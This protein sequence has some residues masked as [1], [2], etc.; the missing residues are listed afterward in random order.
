MKLLTAEKAI[1]QLQNQAEKIK[2]DEMQRFPAAASFG[3]TWRQ[4]DLYITLIEKVPETAQKAQVRLQLADGN[5]Q[6]SRHCLDSKVGVKMFT[7]ANPEMLDG[8]ILKT[9]TERTIEHPEHGNVVLPPACYR[10]T[11]QRDLDAEDRQRRVLD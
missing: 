4:G 11:Y 8:P 1:I 6:G 7:L 3:D 9:S 10:I 2:N 5:T